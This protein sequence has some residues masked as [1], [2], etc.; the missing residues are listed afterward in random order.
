MSPEEH[1][2]QKPRW[3]PLEEGTCEADYYHAH[4][5]RSRW[6]RGADAA[7]PLLTR[8]GLLRSHHFLNTSLC[9]KRVRVCVIPCNFIRKNIYSLPT[10]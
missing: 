7:V 3:T 1:L 9:A 5:R 8:P 4:T 2:S 6:S 10:L